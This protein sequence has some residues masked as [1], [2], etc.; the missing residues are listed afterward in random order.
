[1]H[2]IPSIAHS[3]LWISF[4]FL[5]IAM[6]VVDL[7][8][9][10][11]NKAHAPSIKKALAFSL[12]WIL[13]ALLFNL[14]LWIYLNQIQGSA[15]ADISALNFLT[16]YLVEKSLSI[17][18]LFI[19]LMIFTSFKIPANLQKR[20]FTYGIL[21]AII[22]RGIMIALGATLVS[23][24][25]WI[26]YIFGA[27]LFLT[28]IKMAFSKTA[29]HE[30]KEGLFIRLCKKYMRIT[31]GLRGQLF[32]IIERG[33]LYA[34]PL[35]LVL[36]LIEF[37]DLAFATDSIP[38]IFAITQDPF[39]IFSSNI[40]AILGLRALY[41]VLAGMLSRFAYLHYGL[42]L[43]L[44]LI[45]VKLLIAPFYHISSVVTLL[46]VFVILLGSV[47]LSLFFPKK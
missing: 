30:I 7:F 11:G 37:S 39:I 36:L 8:C 27:F 5:V 14:G 25:A 29:H 17:D 26:L 38:A 12:F 6:F 13:L 35:F 16:G 18:N 47:M 33:L 42:A 19:F 41:F 20:V 21:G 22:L 31:D 34:T 24:F 2:Q 9:F 44:T 46:S 28:G 10:G 32:F 23:E 43:I 45:G 40:F 4:S 3:T 1:M 15:V